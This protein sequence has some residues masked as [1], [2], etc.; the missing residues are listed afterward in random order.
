[1]RA[2][3]RPKKPKHEIKAAYKRRIRGYILY[4]KGSK[5]K[6]IIN[7]IKIQLKIPR[8]QRMSII[9]TEY[10]GRKDIIEKILEDRLKHICYGEI[11]EYLEDNKEFQKYVER[12]KENQKKF[13]GIFAGPIVSLGGIK[14]K[15]NLT[16]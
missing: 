9:Y 5:S 11:P 14:W 7:I 1:M 16:D 3:N 2:F 13:V 6:S 12:E 15:K 10:A 8:Y 4:T